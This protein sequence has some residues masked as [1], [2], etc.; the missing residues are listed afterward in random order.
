MDELIN[1]FHGH[2]HPVVGR[3]VSL[4]LKKVSANIVDVYERKLLM[5]V[6]LRDV[7]VE[8]VVTV[9]VQSALLRT[10]PNV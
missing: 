9:L 7:D 2:V 8:V 6:V 5:Y 1:L 3:D 10:W 4:Q